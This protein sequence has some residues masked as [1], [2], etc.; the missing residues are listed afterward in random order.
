MSERRNIFH[1]QQLH[2]A[3]WEQSCSV[4]DTP[5][6]ALTASHSNRESQINSHIQTH[7]RVPTSFLAT[8]TDTSLSI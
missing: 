5:L 6:T 8:Y 2:H 3:A 1:H 4:A 7:P